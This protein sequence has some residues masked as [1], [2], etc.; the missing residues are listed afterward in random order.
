VVFSLLAWYHLRFLN[1]GELYGPALKILCLTTRTTKHLLD[2]FVLGVLEFG[3]D[4][5]GYLLHVHVLDEL[6][7]Q[8]AL[9]INSVLI[10]LSF[11][12][13]H[14]CFEDCLLFLGFRRLATEQVSWVDLCDCAISVLLLNSDDNC[15]SSCLFE[16]GNL[17]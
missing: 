3:R 4:V 5:S 16:I 7:I 1:L 12:N 6:G 15:A 17:G 14:L 10:E 8:V 9:S 11:V 2:A 13:Q